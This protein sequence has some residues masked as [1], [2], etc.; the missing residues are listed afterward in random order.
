MKQQHYYQVHRKL[1]IADKDIQHII[2]LMITAWICL[3]GEVYIFVVIASEHFI[4]IT[5]TEGSTYII[6]D[7]SFMRDQEYLQNMT[8][9]RSVSRS[10]LKGHK[11]GLQSGI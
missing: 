2:P 7:V 1:I 4:L 3:V 11:L 6:N 10:V 5:G 8:K 9:H